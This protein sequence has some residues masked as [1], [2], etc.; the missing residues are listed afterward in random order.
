MREQDRSETRAC[1]P[2]KFQ[3]QIWIE[4]IE[5]MAK[6]P[7]NIRTQKT[8][9]QH[10]L[11]NSI[12]RSGFGLNF[13]VNTRDDRLGVELWM[14][15]EDAKQHFA[16]IKVQKAQIEAALGFELDWQELPDSRASRIAAWLNDVN[17]TDEACRPEYLQWYADTVS[18]MDAVLRPIVKALP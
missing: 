6:D 18:K 14:P 4:L 10:W 12:G 2:K 13:T 7:P 16:R 3:L 8:R 9:P 11:N 15:G 1:S 17:P 5:K